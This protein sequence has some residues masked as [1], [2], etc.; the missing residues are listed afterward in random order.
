V[1]DGPLVTSRTHPAWFRAF[2]EQLK[3]VAPVG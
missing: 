3:K 1:I 2:I